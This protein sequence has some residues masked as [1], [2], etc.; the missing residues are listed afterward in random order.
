LD[1]GNNGTD[2][3]TAGSGQDTLISGHRYHDVFGGAGI[4]EFDVNNSADEI[5]LPFFNGGS[6]TIRASVDYTLILLWAPLS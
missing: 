4:D 1:Q 3:L 2:T 6:D 5:D